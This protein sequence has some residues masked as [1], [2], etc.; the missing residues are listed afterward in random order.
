[1]GSGIPEPEAVLIQ[2]NATADDRIVTDMSSDPELAALLETFFARQPSGAFMSSWIGRRLFWS[3]YMRIL[4][5]VTPRRAL[6]WPTRDFACA[7]EELDLH[8]VRRVG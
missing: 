1:M 7:P 6:Y 2:G 8:E 3:Y 5:Y 4:I